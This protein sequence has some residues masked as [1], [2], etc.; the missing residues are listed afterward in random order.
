MKFIA[1][2]HIHSKYSRATAKNLDLENIYIAAQIKGITVVGTGDFT[3][4]GW[5]SEIKE[6]LEE[7]EPGL[8]KLK[9][10]FSERC[11][12]SV[13]Q[14][15]RNKVRFILQTE[16]SNIYKK[17]NRVRKNHNLVFFKNID[18]IERFNERLDKIGNIKSDGRPILGLDARDLL[19]IV[20]ETSDGGVLIPAHIWTPWFSMLGSKSGFDAVEECFEDL[21]EHI[22]AAETGLSSD[23][24]MNWRVSKL[25][26]MTLISNSDA[27]SP[28][29]LGREANIF[30]THLSY[31]AIFSAL[32]NN[33]KKQFLGTY[34]FFPEEGKYHLDGHRKCGVHLFPE[35]TLKKEGICP[36]C[37]KK[38]TLGV[39]YR[40]AQLADR[41]FGKKPDRANP[42]H[43]IVPLAH[44][45]S[46]IF[47]VGPQSKAVGKKYATA[48]ETLGP[49]FEILHTLSIEK[50][51]KA[52][53]PLLGEAIRR[54][55]TNRLNISPGYD[56]EYGKVTFFKPGE[57][58][59]LMGQRCLF[60][61]PESTMGLKKPKDV[62]KI[63]KR[64]KGSTQKQ[65]LRIPETLNPQQQ[66]AVESK[67][68]YLL[69][70]AGPGTGK[71]STLTRRISFL[72]DKK[73]ISAHHILALTFTRKAAKEML[74]RL[75][76]TLK[77]DTKLP[78]VVTF[79]SLCVKILRDIEG[80]AFSVVDDIDRG[81]LI[82]EAIENV[83]EKR[84]Q[85]TISASKVLEK[86]S[87]AK[88]NTG[89]TSFD[90][91]A[92]E[93]ERTFF[94][95]VYNRYQE[96]LAVQN[97]YDF[98]DLIVKVVRLFEKEAS[99]RRHYQACFR[100]IFVDEYQDLNQ[101]QV[102]LLNIIAPPGSRI[103][104]SGADFDKTSDVCVIG[105]P[106]QS[107][108]GFRGS[109]IIYFKN[110][111]KD[112]PDTEVIHLTRNYRSTETILA[113]SYQIIKHHQITL[114]RTRTYSDIAG[115]GTITVLES[116]SEKAEA[117]AVGKTVE[118]LVGGL[119]FHSM[120]FKNIAT[121]KEDTHYGFS[122]FAVLFRTLAQ[123]EI[124]KEILEVA[125]IPCQ[126]A[127]KENMFTQ[128]GIAEI[129]SYLK[130]TASVGSFID[131][132]RVIAF[133]KPGIGKKTTTVFKN[134]CYQNQFNL[135]NGMDNALRLPIKGINTAKQF[136]L[137]DFIKK[138]I[139]LKEAS[140]GL[141]VAE[142]LDYIIH[143]TGTC[144]IIESDEKIQ[145]I[146]DQITVNARQYGKE[147]IS[148]LCDIT[149]QTDSDSY[150][151]KAEKVSLMTMH[152]A[153]GL[154]F[155]V[156]FIAGCEDGFLPFERNGTVDDIEE[157]RRLFYVA[158]TRAKQKLY[159]SYAKKRCLYGKSLSRQM[160]PFVADIAPH[161]IEYEKKYGAKKK[162]P[163]QLELF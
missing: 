99:V 65:P 56:G 51:D 143:N 136:K 147:T 130:I 44:I 70:V 118:T 52:G 114:E 117:V 145:N 97:L 60:D 82:R 43:C 2:L 35:E 37:G 59:T 15:C 31:D 30:D 42:Y 17:N 23:P 28:R 107:I 14:S 137:T 158:M 20:L 134:W 123:G 144:A 19:E 159:L 81:Y 132:E 155:S 121:E 49:E 142:K 119:G 90:E 157:E 140:K 111:K 32:K 16:I 113:A 72:I 54:M 120:D 138:T 1:D 39:L 58:K 8:F 67:S 125:G 127:S 40:V 115:P 36:V 141:S 11:D 73:N 34:E 38:L 133:S 45:L 9:K 83:A 69:I 27:H 50:I 21:S 146:V 55:R 152:A 162:R 80:T 105:D 98:D 48:I 47:R 33:N 151:E 64:K 110:F 86:I 154:E 13:P 139:T 109:D 93:K 10:K 3:H 85:K 57:R 153:K 29:N 68:N 103:R 26:K 160:S 61:I 53:I 24:A 74:I 135:S 150:D 91:I 62:K 161:L 94:V 76:N 89:D 116:V 101:V 124:F 156:V 6:K 163:V 12:Q 25:D 63:G 7:A 5:V 79:H 112:Y 95:R 88:Q 78:L 108:Y 41:E 122:D 149:L 46:D 129:L 66:K 148:F 131:F 77:T 84:G 18:S 104:S 128:K 106:D 100:Y 75:K 96:L 4:P 126:I 71:T 102:R 87:L 22:F 92:I